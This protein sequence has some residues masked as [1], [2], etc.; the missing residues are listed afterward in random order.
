MDHNVFPPWQ[1]PITLPGGKLLV[2]NMVAVCGGE[3]AG[4]LH[5]CDVAFQIND[6]TST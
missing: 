3:G 6:L 1:M 4:T 5:G 2:T